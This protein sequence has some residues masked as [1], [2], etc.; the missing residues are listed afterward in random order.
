MANLESRIEKLEQAIG[1]ITKVVVVYG[2]APV[3]DDENVQVYRVR[4]VRPKVDTNE[5]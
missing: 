1:G 3:P 4:Y 5:S 2:D